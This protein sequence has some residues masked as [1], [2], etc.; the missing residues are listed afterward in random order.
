MSAVVGSAFG[1]VLVV[2]TVAGLPG[3]VS[4]HDA[5]NLT[6]IAVARVPVV[7]Q[8]SAALSTADTGPSLANAHTGGSHFEMPSNLDAGRWPYP[9]VNLPAPPELAV[10]QRRSQRPSG[11]P[12]LDAMM[13]S[14]NNQVRSPNWSTDLL[15]Y[16]KS[17]GPLVDEFW[18]RTLGQNGYVYH[19]PRYRV[20]PEGEVVMT[21]CIDHSGE[22]SPAD[23]LAYC[24]ADETIYIYE[25]FLRDELIAGQDWRS[26]DYVIATVIAHEWAH[27]IQTVHNYDDAADMAIVN[28]PNQWP[29]V[30][31]QGELQADCFAGL[32]TRYARD[33]GWLNIGDIDEAKEALF[34][35]GDHHFESPGHHG[36]P[37]QRREWFRRGYVYYSLAA[38]D[39]W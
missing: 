32:F 29:L 17:I 18:A 19:P 38:C 20:I 6:Q 11:D 21:P 24:P 8:S 9:V 34:R 22:P 39:A 16:T 27:H 26:R 37:E 30:T 25:P 10:V 13:P 33:S 7:E 5:A 36:T 14:G 12:S 15:T 4:P 23:S 35:A 1:E 2:T 31:R 28:D 3:T